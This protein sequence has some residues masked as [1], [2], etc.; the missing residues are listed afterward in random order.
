[1]SDETKNV[2]D[3]LLTCIGMIGVV[4]GF[5]CA[6]AEWRVSQWWRRSE[7][8][9]RM[10]ELFESDARLGLATTV[11]DYTDGMVEYRGRQI[12]FSN[13]EAL[14]A[15]RYHGDLPR[16]VRYSPNEGDIRVAYDAFLTFCKRLSL[17][18]EAGRIEVEPAKLYFKYWLK[19][20][21]TM[22]RH[23]DDKGLLMNPQNVTR[24]GSP[25]DVA[26]RYVEMYGEPEGKDAIENLC[27][28]LGVDRFATGEVP[29]NLRQI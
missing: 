8:L 5:F 27:Q 29:D 9:N 17:S 15:L 28:R 21:L 11:I 12:T 2:L 6:R 10:V 4:V 26:W 19:L 7:E 25:R 14:L 3:V 13:D 23:T 22:S 24:T 20:F 1:M 16:G 18:I